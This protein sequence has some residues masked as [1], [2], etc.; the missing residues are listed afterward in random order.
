MNFKNLCLRALYISHIQNCWKPVRVYILLVVNLT[1]KGSAKKAYTFSSR[2][3]EAEASGSLSWKPVLTT[4][5]VPEQPGIHGETSIYFS[6]LGIFFTNHKLYLL[7]QFS[8]FIF[9]PVTATRDLTKNSHFIS[10]PFH[11]F[12]VKRQS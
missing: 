7:N 4:E 10:T 5:K 2:T 11:C 9:C 8:Y 1:F 12:I 6:M 3:W